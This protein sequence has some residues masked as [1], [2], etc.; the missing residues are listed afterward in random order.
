MPFEEASVVI[1]VGTQNTKA[2]FAGESFP[3]CVTRTLIGRFRHS[4]I[5]D[6]DQMIYFG[7][8]AVRNRGI[9]NLH[10][11]IE[12]GRVTNWDDMEKLW[13]H[14]FY[15]QL[16]IPPEQ[17]RLVHAVNPMSNIKEKKKMAEILFEVFAIKGL[18]IAK[19]PI[20]S[21]FASGRT[22]G[23]VWGNGYSCCCA[24][25]VFEGFPLKHAIVS[26]ELSGAAITEYLSELVTKLGYQLTTAFEKDIVEEI[27]AKMCYVSHDYALEIEK[28]KKEDKAVFK[29]PDG[30][31]IL[32]G[33]ERTQ[34]P[35]IFFQPNLAGRY[36]PSVPDIICNSINKCDVDYRPLFFNNI[37]VSGGSTMFPGLCGRLKAEMRAKISLPGVE[38]KVDGIPNR[39]L[40]VWAG[41]SMMACIDTMKGFWLTSEEY[42][43]C[44]DEKVAYK[45][46]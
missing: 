45:F 9:L 41:G 18:Y 11:P 21:L 7:D 27:K 4:G 26:T 10:Y 5:V 46:F 28:L 8:N 24:T 23:L 43:D 30:Q 44:G 13:H 31:Q 25:P 17:S 38:A 34:C 20:L 2:G 40:S 12:E 16:H 33:P 1:H 39:S 15:S 42:Q 6:G 19:A 32:L 22:S 36:C 35:E 37:V 14:I 29:L 3:R